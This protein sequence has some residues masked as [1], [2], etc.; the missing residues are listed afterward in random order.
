MDNG[1]CLSCFNCCFFNSFN[2]LWLSIFQ[3]ISSIC[4]IVVNSYILSLSK[5]IFD[6]SKFL[7]STHVINISFFS[8]GTTLSTILLFLKKLEKFNQGCFYQFSWISSKIYS[9]CS[10]ILVILNIFGFFYMI[11]FTQFLVMEV[12][13]YNGKKLFNSTELFKRTGPGKE[14]E[15]SLRYKNKELYCNKYH[16]CTEE[17]LYDDEEE[18]YGEV[19]ISFLLSF[20]SCLITF[21]N[22]ESF[23]SDSKRIKFLSPGKISLELRPIDAVSNLS[24]Q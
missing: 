1:C 4:G 13:E 12:G 22:G 3:I 6:S 23:S 10:K 21:F 18:N 19:A 20:L 7:F 15:Y 2:S 5:K 11:G 9:I 14:I 16:N 8:S 17:L 24:L